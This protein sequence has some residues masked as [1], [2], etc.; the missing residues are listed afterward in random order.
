[1]DR[2]FIT[3]DSEL[4]IGLTTPVGVNYDLINK[5]FETAF[6]KYSMKINKVRVTNLIKEIKK[7]RI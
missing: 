2:S 6:K 5:Y 7:T 3:Q 4:V 1:M